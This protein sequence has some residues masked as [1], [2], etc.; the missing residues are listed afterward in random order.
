MEQIF[1][2]GIAFDFE[3][4]Y[5][6][7]YKDCINQVDLIYNRTLERYKIKNSYEAVLETYNEVQHFI[8]RNKLNQG[9]EVV[10]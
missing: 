2:N 7:G 4:G 5:T 10:V 6:C 9:E 8:Q 1:E 3:D